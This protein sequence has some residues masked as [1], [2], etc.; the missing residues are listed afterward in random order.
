L[1]AS[2]VDGVIYSVSEM[3]KLNLGR[4]KYLLKSVQPGSGCRHTEAEQS[5]FL[6][7]N[8][9]IFSQSYSHL[10]KAEE[11]VEWRVYTLLLTVHG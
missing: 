3:K 8:Q 7:E 2:T 10:T 9:L 11:V 1:S 5:I 4:I 6:S